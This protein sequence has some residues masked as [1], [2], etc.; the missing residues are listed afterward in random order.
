[1]GDEGWPAR[2]RRD[3][4]RRPECRRPRRCQLVGACVG[5]HAWAGRVRRSPHRGPIVGADALHLSAR[6]IAQSRVAPTPIRATATPYSRAPAPRP[7]AS[8][9]ASVAG[10]AQHRA[11]GPA[12]HVKSI[13]GSCRAVCR[14]IRHRPAYSCV[15]VHKSSASAP[16]R[17]CARV[18]PLL[19]ASPRRVRQH[20]PRLPVSWRVWQQSRRSATAE[21]GR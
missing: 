4:T 2:R 16:S 15:N 18:E 11:A 3:R 9:Q 7:H 5:A 20:S 13:P 19:A 12:Q 1:M 8:C 6:H 21:S 10:Y 17:E 14:A